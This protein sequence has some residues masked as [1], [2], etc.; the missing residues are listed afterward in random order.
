MGRLEYCWYAYYLYKLHIWNMVDIVCVCELMIPSVLDLRCLQRRNLA[1]RKQH[2]GRGTELS[3]ITNNSGRVVFHHILR[4][5]SQRRRGRKIPHPLPRH[6]AS[7]LGL[8]GQLRRDRLAGDS[9]C[10]LVRDPERQRRQC[11]PGNDRCDLAVFLVPEERHPSQPGD[12]DEWDGGVYDFLACA[13][14]VSVFASR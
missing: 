8:L 9:R 4:D 1:I 14:P 13:V 3:R 2:H 5:R 10:I 7:Q 11:S 12:H 6:R